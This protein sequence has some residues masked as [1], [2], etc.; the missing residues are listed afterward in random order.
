MIMWLITRFDDYLS[1]V[2]WNIDNHQGTVTLVVG[3]FV[4]FIYRFQKKDRKSDAAK[5]VLQEIRYAEAKIRNYRVHHSYTF[6]EK[7]LPTNSWNANIGLFVKDLKE[8]ELD[9]ISVF[10]SNAAYLDDVLKTISDRH[11]RDVL[12]PADPNKPATAS[13]IDTGSIPGPAKELIESISGVIESVFKT[14]TSTKL[15][16]IAERKWYH[17]F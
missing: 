14:P 11:N 6:T 4:F 2:L 9:L 10:Y 5:L 3:V 7:I 17:L 13:Q 8:T 15:T 12:E 1:K 16:E